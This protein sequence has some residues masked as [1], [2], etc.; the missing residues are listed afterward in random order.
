MKFININLATLFLLIIGCSVDSVIS[1]TLAFFEIFRHG[2]RQPLSME[3]ATLQLLYGTGAHQLT[4]NGFKQHLLLGKIFKNLKF[5]ELFDSKNTKLSFVSSPRERCIFS[6]TGQILGMFPGKNINYINSNSTLDIKVDDVPPGFKNLLSLKKRKQDAIFSS[7]SDSI[8][9]I[10]DAVNLR[11]V[12]PDNDGMFH[13]EKCFLEGVDLESDDSKDII[14][15]QSNSTDVNMNSSD[16]L[17]GNTTLNST[18]NGTNTNSTLSDN[19]STGLDNTSSLTNTTNLQNITSQNI[20]T[21]TTE[22]NTISSDNNTTASDNSTNNIGNNTISSDNNSTYSSNNTT[23]IENDIMNVGGNNTI[24]NSTQ[25]LNNTALNNSTMSNLSDST[26][27]NS[28]TNQ[29]STTDNSTLINS[30][31]NSTLRLY[32]ETKK[33]NI[34]SRHNLNKDSRS[35]NFKFPSI[36]KNIAKEVKSKDASLHRKQFETIKEKL[37]S[38]KLFEFTPEEIKNGVDSIVKG[39][40]EAFSSRVK[41][42]DWEWPFKESNKYTEKSLGR[43]VN[44]IVPLRY[45]FIGATGEKLNF[46]DD[47]EKI[48]KKCGINHFYSH[49]LNKNKFQRLLCSELLRDVLST[50]DSEEKSINLYSGHDTNIVN[51][52]TN[53]LDVDKIK[54][55][56]IE[57]VEKGKDDDY[58]F[59]IPPFASN[60]VFE[61]VRDEM[62]KEKF[63]KVYYNNKELSEDWV[64]GI[65]YTK[66]QGIR[67]EEFK[68][69]FSARIIDTSSGKWDCKRDMDRK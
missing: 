56:L 46:S 54:P 57:S 1:E 17:I 49:K 58:E 62:T 45:H 39:L 60:I 28:T 23:N 47:V 27:L 48:I 67:K 38:S 20:N 35:K 65:T 55:K 44:F 26:S 24:T 22:N 16:A 15:N 36:E 31:Q 32:K 69:V 33:F 12:D 2:A 14:P 18:L 13:P 52:L 42:E 59:Y 11:I 30:T 5:K 50:F 6:A 41:A 37:K 68:Q 7:D 61:L 4:P 9:K 3:S 8:S 43:L 10:L 63:V 34:Q 53:L 21:N 64:S 29:N 25:T 19:N 51:C 40:T 66:G